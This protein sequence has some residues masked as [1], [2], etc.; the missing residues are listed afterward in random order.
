MRTCSEGI[1]I[2]EATV[3]NGHTE[4]QHYQKLVR[5]RVYKQQVLIERIP[6]AHVQ[7]R[8]GADALKYR[9]CHCIAF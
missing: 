2:C 7:Y 1:L 9:C 5:Y 8:C 3:P 6:R 4:H